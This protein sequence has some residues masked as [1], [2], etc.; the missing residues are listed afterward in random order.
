MFKFHA[1]VLDPL[2]ADLKQLEITCKTVREL[3]CHKCA[4]PDSLQPISH[5]TISRN[6][7]MF[8]VHVTPFVAS[9]RSTPPLNNCSCH[10]CVNFI[11]SRC[12]GVQAPF[13]LPLLLFMCSMCQL[14]R[15][16]CYGVQ[17]IIVLSEG[18]RHSELTPFSPLLLRM[19]YKSA[20]LIT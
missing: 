13:T 7:W 6:H 2:D 17:V 11:T 9:G 20:H 18:N 10:R 19:L 14:I 1:P 4:R 15:S 3:V 12:Y 8:N 16:R 5:V